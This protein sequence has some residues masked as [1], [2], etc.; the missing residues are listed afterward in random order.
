MG[1]STISMAIFNI[2]F[3][4]RVCGLS[5]FALTALFVHSVCFFL[6]LIAMWLT[7]VGALVCWHGG[8]TIDD[9]NVGCCWEDGQHGFLHVKS[10]QIPMSYQIRSN[11]NV[12]FS[13]SHHSSARFFFH[14]FLAKSGS[15][16]RLLEVFQEIQTV[17]Y[18][19][20]TF[21]SPLR[22]PAYSGPTWSVK[23]FA[24]SW[25]QHFQKVWGIHQ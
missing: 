3:P 21:D 23:V 12:F 10:H 18:L 24:A 9:I 5:C 19:G 15:P 14:T 20:C 1:K 6:C 16:L 25:L 22:I 17:S 13:V 2:F 8:W 7:M 4:Q 11:S